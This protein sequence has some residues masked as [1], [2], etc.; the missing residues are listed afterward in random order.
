[1]QG[2]GG[3]RHLCCHRIASFC[4]H[5]LCC[6]CGDFLFIT[7]HNEQQ[8]LILVDLKCITLASMSITCVNSM[9][10]TCKL[11]LGNI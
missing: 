7:L 5:L 3:W 10:M 2:V 11:K 1:M 8:D 9:S 4:E 6:G